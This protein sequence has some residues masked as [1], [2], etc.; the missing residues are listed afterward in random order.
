MFLNVLKRETRYR[1]KG[2]KC[3]NRNA[4]S[5]KKDKILKQLFFIKLSSSFHSL[6]PRSPNTNITNP[7]L[8]P[9]R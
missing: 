9:Y 5:F 3:V 2:R 8:I 1:K 7:R 6:F 4:L